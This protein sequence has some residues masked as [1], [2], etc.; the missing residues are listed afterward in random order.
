[1]NLDYSYDVSIW[2]TSGKT[3]TSI[4]NKVGVY[5][6]WYYDIIYQPKTL[7]KLKSS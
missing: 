2:C 3:G 7:N 6:R 5:T 1:M 4:C